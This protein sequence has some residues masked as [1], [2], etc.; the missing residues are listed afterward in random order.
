MENNV[1][2]AKIK[3]FK[4][5]KNNLMKFLVFIVAIAMVAFLSNN[6]MAQSETTDAGA[7]I[8]TAMTITETADMHFGTMTVPTEISEV[9]LAVGGTVS[10]ASGTLTLLAQTPT[11][12]AAAY[13]I[14]GDVSASYA[15]TLPENGVVT[16]TEGATPIPVKDFICSYG[17]KTSSLDGSGDDN[18]TVGATIVLAD[19]QPAGTYIGTFDV[20]VD[21]N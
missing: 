15:I 11:S 9:D 12:H 2:Y 19:A 5:L 17:D 21:Y 6:A 7:K 3:L 8:L 10:V 16:I 1:S 20:S 14:T 18:F 13:D 4:P